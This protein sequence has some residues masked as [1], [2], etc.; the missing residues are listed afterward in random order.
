[1]FEKVNGLAIDLMRFHSFFSRFSDGMKIIGDFVKNCILTSAYLFVGET[2][3]IRIILRRINSKADNGWHTRLRGSEQRQSPLAA[4]WFSIRHHRP[5]DRTGSA[6]GAA[7]SER[8]RGC[9]CR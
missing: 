9:L 2:V 4:S 3:E 5:L 6:M 1:M 8:A 7:A